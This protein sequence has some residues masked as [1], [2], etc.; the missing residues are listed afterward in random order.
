MDVIAASA[1]AYKYYKKQDQDLYNSSIA[2]MLRE[3]QR[4]V[5][6]HIYCFTSCH[7]SQLRSKSGLDCSFMAILSWDNN[8]TQNHEKNL[9]QHV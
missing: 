3:M 1:D 6:L 5:R 8:W 4:K 2:V 7:F 9:E